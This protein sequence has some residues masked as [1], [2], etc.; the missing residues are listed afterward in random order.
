MNEPIDY[1]ALLVRYMAQ[2]IDCEGTSF[3]NGMAYIFKLTD[4][5]LI[6]L[7]KI[8]AEARKEYNL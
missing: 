3:I 2:V 1:R 7:D 5:E 8:E 6:I 4:E